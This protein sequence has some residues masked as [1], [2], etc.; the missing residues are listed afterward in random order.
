MKSGAAFTFRVQFEN[1]A[2]LEL[3]ALLYAVEL[4]DQMVHRLGY[5]KP[6]GF[7][8][9]K[10]TVETVEIVNWKKRITAP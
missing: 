9:V 1:L 3:G 4:E 5:A 2:P 6:L 8:S 10:V 7:G